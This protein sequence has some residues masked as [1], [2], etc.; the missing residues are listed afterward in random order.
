MSFDVPATSVE[1]VKASSVRYRNGA[2]A[3]CAFCSC[4]AAWVK[5]FSA[6]AGP[7]EPKAS[8]AGRAS[9]DESARLAQD[10]CRSVI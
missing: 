3:T 9:A 1:I 5:G 6:L 4:N 7:F 2:I 8:R 10:V